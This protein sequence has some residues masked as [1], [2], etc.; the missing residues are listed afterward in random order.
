MLG[1]VASMAL[2]AT[3]AALGSGSG[4][5][6]QRDVGKRPQQRAVLPSGCSVTVT[7]DSELSCLLLAL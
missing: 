6:Q 1:R 3:G 2:Q 7:R 4:L 5:A